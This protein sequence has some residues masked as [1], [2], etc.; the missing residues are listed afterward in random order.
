[1]S[2][3]KESLIK[4]V[5]SMRRRLSSIPSSG[6]REIEIFEEQMSKSLKRIDKVSY[7]SK[8]FSLADLAEIHKA[9]EELISPRPKTERD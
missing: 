4:S 5:L 6:N 2:E 3:S 7:L 9:Y 8:K 1:M